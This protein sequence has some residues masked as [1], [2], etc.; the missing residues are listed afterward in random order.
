MGQS[1]GNGSARRVTDDHLRIPSFL[2]AKC[3][4]VLC[5]RIQPGSVTRAKLCEAVA[6]Q[7]QCDHVESFG[8]V[9][10]KRPITVG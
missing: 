1:Q 8:K 7:V 2:H 3:Y 9:A 10:Q 5:H 6:W 4:D